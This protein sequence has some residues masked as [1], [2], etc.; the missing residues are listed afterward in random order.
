MVLFP[1]VIRM[2]SAVLAGRAAPAP[3]FGTVQNPIKMMSVEH[4]HAGQA[5]RAIRAASRD[6]SVPSGGCATYQVL[7]QGLE[8]FEQDLHRHIYLENSVLFPRAV[9]LEEKCL[10]HNRLDNQKDNQ[11]ERGT[12][13]APN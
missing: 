7:Y 4:D 13:L 12:K 6:Y 8:A 10:A 9:E 3:P 1:H 11:K 5:L 2:E